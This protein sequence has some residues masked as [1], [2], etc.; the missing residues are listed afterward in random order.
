MLL[1]DLAIFGIYLLA[2]VCAHKAF[3]RHEAG[4]F[5]AT[6][7]LLWG[8]FSVHAAR[9]AYT[10]WSTGHLTLS[11]AM[12]LNLLPA[13]LVGL[14][15][16][17]QMTHKNDYAVMFVAP[18]A[19]LMLGF[20]LG[21]QHLG[22]PEALFSGSPW[23][24]VHV[25]CL[26][27]AYALLGIGGLTAL[28]YLLLALLMRQTSRL[29]KLAQGVSLETLSQHTDRCLKWGVLLLTLGLAGG[30][31][32]MLPD[33][34]WTAGDAF[35]ALLSG[36]TWFLYVSVV[37]LRARGRLQGRQGMVWVSLCFAGLLINLL[38]N[39]LTTATYHRIFL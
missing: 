14:S 8:A 36:T 9:L 19:T 33:L 35:K 3:W 25:Q 17:W 6:Q 16:L 7:R 39:S 10:F 29:G 22:Q 27:M 2:S 4:W 15:L 34:S 31:V 26:I 30:I 11:F 32:R 28:S 23:L 20:S 1:I 18:L 13:V 21:L 5:H 38:S 24:W 12:F 37:S